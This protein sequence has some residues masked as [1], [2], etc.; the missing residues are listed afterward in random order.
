MRDIILGLP[1]FYLITNHPKDPLELK[2]IKAMQAIEE[3]LKVAS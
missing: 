2:K 3:F 1:P